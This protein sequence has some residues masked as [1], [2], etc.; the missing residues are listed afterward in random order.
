MAISILFLHLRAPDIPSALSFRAACP[1]RTLRQFGA[2][3][4]RNRPF[5]PRRQHYCARNLYNPFPAVWA[6]ANLQ[7]T[8]P[9]RL[10][11]SGGDPTSLPFPAHGCTRNDVASCTSGTFNRYETIN[12]ILVWYIRKQCAPSNSYLTI[13]T[14]YRDDPTYRVN[15]DKIVTQIIRSDLRRNS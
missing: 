3:R 12:E 15:G 10:R 1:F 2:L 14:C 8:P 11:F 13:G 5:H 4:V 9:T 6:L 7:R